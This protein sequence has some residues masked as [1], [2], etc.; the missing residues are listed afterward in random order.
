ML[1]LKQSPMGK[2]MGKIDMDDVRSFVARNPIAVKILNGL[3]LMV[4][5]MLLFSFV[6]WRDGLP[7]EIQRHLN[8][9]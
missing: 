1:V 3:R 5:L 6:L 2:L 7:S 4:A 9:G 8:H